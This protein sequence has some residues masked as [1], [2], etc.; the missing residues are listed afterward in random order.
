MLTQRRRP[1][2]PASTPIPTLK[3]NSSHR[4]GIGFRGDNDSSLASSCRSLLAGFKCCSAETSNACARG[5]PTGNPRSWCFKGKPEK[6]CGGGQ[7]Q[8]IREG[9]HIQTR[10]I[11]RPTLPDVAYCNASVGLGVCKARK[12]NGQEKGRF[13]FKAKRLHRFTRLRQTYTDTRHPVGH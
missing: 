11:N 10:S 1:S 5:C 2:S 6:S 4:R 12:H 8:Q 9:P 3:K 13:G 7:P